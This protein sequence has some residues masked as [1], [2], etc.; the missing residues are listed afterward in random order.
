MIERL[1]E[2]ELEV[3]RFIAA[4]LS[5]KKIMDELFISMNTV[6]THL[7]NIYS[8]LNVNSRTQAVAKAKEL[9]LL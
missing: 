7:R 2:R 6:K 9:D 3:L 8:K 4:G 5:N 1:S